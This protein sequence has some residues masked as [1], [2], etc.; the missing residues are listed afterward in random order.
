MRLHKSDLQLFIGLS[1]L[2]FRRVSGNAWELG[3][4]GPQIIG[5]PVP[6]KVR[7]ESMAETMLPEVVN[8]S[9][10]PANRSIVSPFFLE[11]LATH[12]QATDLLGLEHAPHCVGVAVGGLLFKR[13][14]YSNNAIKRGQRARGLQITLY[15][16]L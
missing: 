16:F 8:I 13:V 15:L 4:A 2:P 12:G 3:N 9:P 6:H 14:A 1:F 10:Q 7:V 11:A 5:N